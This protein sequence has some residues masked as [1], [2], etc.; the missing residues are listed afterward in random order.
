MGRVRTLHHAFNIGVVDKD[1]L[2]RVDLERMRLAAEQQ[3]NLLPLTTGAMFVRPGTEYI[4]ETP[5]SEEVLLREFV[6]G[7]TDSAL[8]EFGDEKLRIYNSDALLTRGA[9]TSTVGSDL[10][11]Y[12]DISTDGGNVQDTGIAFGAT[13]GF[14]GIELNVTGQGGI[15]GIRQ[16]VSTSNANEQHALRIRVHS[17]SL[18]FKCGS[19]TG[20][21]NFFAKTTLKP[22]THSLAFTPTTSSYYIEFTREE[23]GVGVLQS[24]Q[25]EAAGV[26]EIDAPW[27]TNDLQNVR[28]AQSADVIFVGVGITGRPQRIERRSAE[29]WSIVEFAPFDGPWANYIYAAEDQIEFNS[30]EFFQLVKGTSSGPNLGLDNHPAVGP[31]DFVKVEHSD[32]GVNTVLSAEA[33]F[34]DPIRVTGIKSANWHDREWT[35]TISGTWTGTLK[36]QR[37]FD[38]ADF[39]YKDFRESTASA[40]ID[41]TTNKTS[42]KNED[43]DDNAI[44]YYRLGFSRGDYTSGSAEID[45]SYGGY[46]GTGIFR[47]H[48]ESLTVGSLGNVISPIKGT[49]LS[50]AWKPCAW[51]SYYGFPSA[52]ALFDG[53]LFWIRFDKIWGSISDA[54]ESFDED[55][56]GDAGTIARSIATGGVDGAQWILPL[57]RLV[58]GTSGATISARS[59]S[60]DTPLTPSDFTLRAFDSVGC[61]NVDAVSVDNRGI[62]VERSGKKLFHLVFDGGERDY[63]AHE[64]SKLTNDIFDAGVKQ[65]AVQRRPETRIWAV[66]NDGSVVC[67]V[68]EPEDEVLAFTTVIVADGEVESVAVLPG[69]SADNVY[70]SVKRTIDGSTVRYVEK[71]AKDSEALPNNICVSLDSSKIY[72]DISSTATLTGLDHLEGEEVRVWA[73]GSPLIDTYTVTSGQIT[74]STAV[75]NAVVGL[76]YTARYKSARLAYGGEGG[77]AMGQIKKVNNINMVLTEFV[78]DGVK[79]GP[80]FDNA[81]HPLDPLPVLVDGVSADEISSTVFDDTKLE[82]DGG[83]DVDSRVCL[84]VRSPNVAKFVSLI[85]DVETNG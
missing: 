25:V 58:V 10:I 28:L 27:T 84:E 4:A 72:R 49:G 36:W 77:T 50:S 57:Q 40:T 81:D 62:F 8:L 59:S 78:R 6:F 74:L 41:I 13:Y 44:V 20:T 30:T 48:Y 39:G 31:K 61:A 64:I 38:A 33:Q 45:I 18:R 47:K 79:Y 76:P 43:D 73:D 37:S 14:T 42:I 21:D 75:T 11:D 54:Y 82:F 5:S 3:Q 15:A 32:R 51:S 52:P 66:L 56:E 26:V 67:L 1:K 53:R 24:C 70:F 29:S 17:G 68:Y 71:L 46:G 35:Y 69:S 65:L 23:N 63:K 34:T 7:A 19:A 9:V 22:G 12:T 80:E 2:P 85:L 83:W 16:A 60:F 55:F